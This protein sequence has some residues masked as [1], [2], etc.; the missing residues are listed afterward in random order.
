VC[1]VITV[2]AVILLRDFGPYTF[3]PYVGWFVADY[4]LLKDFRPC[5]TY[6]FMTRVFVITVAMPMLLRDLEPCGIIFFDYVCL[7]IVHDE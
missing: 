4:L 3:S 1:V 2:F 6:V 7:T 5:D